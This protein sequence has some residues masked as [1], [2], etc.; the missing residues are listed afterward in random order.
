MLSGGGERV[1]WLVEFEGSRRQLAD[2]V[3]PEF[4]AAVAPVKSHIEAALAGDIDDPDVSALRVVFSVDPSSGLN[5]TLEGAPLAVNTAVDRL[6]SQAE[7][8]PGRPN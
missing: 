2:I 3:S 8:G 7:V 6:G 4:Q 5:F 1:E